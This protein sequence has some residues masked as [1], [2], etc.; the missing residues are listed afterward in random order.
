MTIRLT[1]F[2]D[3]TMAR[4]DMKVKLSNTYTQHVEKQD[5]VT[6]VTADEIKAK[7]TSYE[8]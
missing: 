8:H 5:D 6:P 2:S 1:K 7:E 3:V 4:A